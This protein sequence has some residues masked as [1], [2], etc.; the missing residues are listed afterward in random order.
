[1]GSSSIAQGDQLGTLRCKKEKKKKGKKEGLSSWALPSVNPGSPLGSSWGV[2]GTRSIPFPSLIAEFLHFAHF[3]SDGRGKWIKLTPKAAI[4]RL[5]VFFPAGDSLFLR[6]L[7]FGYFS[8]FLFPAG[9]SH[10]SFSV[11]F[12]PRDKNNNSH[13]L[14][15]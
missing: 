2:P 6:L 5:L 8:S 7:P 1:M 12:L 3:I 14:R 10:L 9:R 11:S 13:L 15:V 4:S